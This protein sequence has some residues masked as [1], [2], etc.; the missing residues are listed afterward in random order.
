MKHHHDTKFSRIFQSHTKFSSVVVVL[1]GLLLI[2]PALGLE[3]LWGE[4]R[5]Q[6]LYRVNSQ[7]DIQD[8]IEEW[9]YL[10]KRGDVR[11]KIELCQYH[12]SNKFYK[13]A[14]RS[15]KK[16]ARFRDS[17]A[18]YTLGTMYLNGYGVTVNANKAIKWFKKSANRGNTE[19][20]IRL[21][22]MYSKGENVQL[23]HK[24]AAK[25][26]KRAAKQN[27]ATAQNN[28]AIQYLKGQG[29][30][31]NTQK[32]RTLLEQAASNG[33]SLAQYNLSIFYFN[34]QNGKQNNTEAYKWLFISRKTGPVYNIDKRNELYNQ[35]QQSLTLTER[36][37]AQMQAKLWMR[38]RGYQ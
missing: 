37:D 14:L 33:D 30:R 29:I 26:Y 7:I 4:D 34:G 18:Q 19:T 20:Q 11:A 25:W 15:C 36:E 9:Q 31:K 6:V 8:N 32:A 22:R 12:F 23:S 5:R 3:F 28:L 35:L 1:V 38:S 17:S 21:A 27:N 16:A 10:A 2:L 24:K 13:Q